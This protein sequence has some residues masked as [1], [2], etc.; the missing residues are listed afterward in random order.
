[1]KALGGVLTAVATPFDRSGK[2]LL[3]LVP[4]LLEL[5]REAGLTGVVIAGTNGEGPSLSAEER[6]AL[7]ETALA[8]RDGL[9]IVAATGA[10]SVTDAV[11]LARHASDAGA[12]ALLVLPPFFFKNVPVDGLVAYFE[13]VLDASSVPVLLY[14][15]P[16]VSA[17]AVTHEL[18]DRLAG[19]PRLLGLKDSSGDWESTR[20]FIERGDVRVFAG[21]DD[22][23][24][25]A[26]RAGA[27]GA[28]SGTANAAPEL[29]AD[30]LRA[31][32]DGGD[33]E[34]A[35]ARLDAARAVLLRYPLLAGNKAVLTHRGY[36]PMSVRAPLT[37]LAPEVAEALV[38]Q[39]APVAGW[40]VRRA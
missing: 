13:R 1:M 11:S 14:S 15:I 12:D 7:L 25:R 24:A 2:L 22:L 34:A 4:H 18:L 29:V 8:H 26:L 38:A 32:R 19:H 30:V 37:D 17:I 10:A 3:D 6:R 16:Q 21:S 20:G 40:R 39:L 36:G 35:Q 9:T 5:Q 31:W 27:A 33:L 23:L 28:I